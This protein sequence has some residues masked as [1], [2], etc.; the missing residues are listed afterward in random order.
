MIT[1]TIAAN[2]LPAAARIAAIAVLQVLVFIAFHGRLSLLF[3]NNTI[4]MTFEH[5]IAELPP[6]DKTQSH[7]SSSRLNAQPCFQAITAPA[8]HTG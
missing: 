4:Y 1:Q 2:A 6:G 8:A 5:I 7:C 3:E